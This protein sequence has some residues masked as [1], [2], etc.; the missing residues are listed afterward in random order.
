MK[1][2]IF[3]HCAISDDKK[4]VDIMNELLQS[5]GIGSQSIDVD[6]NIFS[7]GKKSNEF[8]FNEDYHHPDYS[9]G[10]FFTLGKLKSFCDSLT[11]NI[12]VCYVMTKGESNGFNNPCII[13][14]R[15]YMSYFVLQNMKTCIDF[16]MDGYDAVG[17]DWATTPS[18]NKHK[19]FSGNFWWASSD[20]I[21]SLPEINPPSFSIDFGAHRHKCEFWIGLNKPKVKSLHQSGIDVLQRHVSPYPEE[22]YK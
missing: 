17:V 14:H 8:W 3:L 11:E 19:H 16:I 10:E 13:D 12:P 9:L 15:K 7:V 6:L 18:L 1:P 5:C 21:K 22:K 20:Y 4:H 2:T